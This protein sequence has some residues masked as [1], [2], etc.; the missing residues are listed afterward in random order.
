MVKIKE[1]EGFHY[2]SKMKVYIASKNNFINP[3]KIFISEKLVGR[4][5]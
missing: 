5:N 2:K 1:K 3:R 4:R